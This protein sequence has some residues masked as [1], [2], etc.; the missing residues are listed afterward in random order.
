MTVNL[1]TK[2]RRLG[3]DGLRYEAR[4]AFLDGRNQRAALRNAETTLAK[5]R[6][7]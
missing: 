6:V 2:D 5:A 3:P 7:P 4:L 1:T